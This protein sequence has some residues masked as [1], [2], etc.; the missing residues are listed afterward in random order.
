MPI[1]FDPN[2]AVPVWL[3]SDAA[4][5]F[6]TRPTFKCRPFTC[7]ASDEWR[8]QWDA[9]VS[10]NCDHREAIGL[11]LTRFTDWRNFPE[12]LSAD[13]IRRHL[14][15][16]EVWEMIKNLPYKCGVSEIDRKKYDLPPDSAGVASVASAPADAHSSQT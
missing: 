11:L 6:P 7:E 16:A 2:T 9:C 15:P 14:S 8:E 3:D 1:S 10:R 4:T 5:P 13:A 12:P